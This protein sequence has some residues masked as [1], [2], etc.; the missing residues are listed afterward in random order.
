MSAAEPGEAFRQ[1]AL[2][3]CAAI[4]AALSSASDPHPAIHSAR[5]AIRRLRSLLALLQHAALDVETADLGL[6]RLGDGLSRL[7]DAH[8]VVEVARHLQE[9]DADRRWNG[10]IRM[11]VLRRDGLLQAT[12]QRDPGFARRLRVLA[13]V[14]QQLA[15]QPW[16]QL[17]RGSLRRNLERSWRRVDKAAA[18]AKRDGGA[19]AVHRWRRRV[20]RLRM[21]LDIACDLQ[22]HVHS[23][24]LHASGHRY[25]ALH[26]LSDELGRQQDLRLLRNL[27]RA[28]PASDDKRSVMQQIN[29]EVAPD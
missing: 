25:K 13:A 4:A 5:K 12:L 20:R 15:V 22:L 28:M 9:R 19:A 8:V 7:R 24:S 14:Q 23:R 2:H 6:K 3:E 16:H 29:G 26:R 10:V 17:R 11:L 21:Q 27:V 18:R 1:S